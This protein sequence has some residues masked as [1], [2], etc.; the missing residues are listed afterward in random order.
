MFD[1]FKYLKS[2][3]VR[4]SKRCIFKIGKQNLGKSKFVE[5]TATL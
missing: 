3:C 2:E 1:E 5:C 4:T